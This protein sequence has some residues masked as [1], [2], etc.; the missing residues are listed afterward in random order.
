MA[1][2]FPLEVHTPYRRFF[3]EQ[4]EAVTLTLADGE[5][6]VYAGHSSFTAPVRTGFLKIKNAEGLW[7]TAFIDAGIVETSAHKT[8]VLSDSAEWPEEIDP[9]R[10]RQAGERAR[11]TLASGILKFETDNAR[12]SLMRAEFRLKVWETENKAPE[13]QRE[14]H[15]S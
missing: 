4:V 1:Q 3:A 14:D 7:R 8:V 9:E 12:A 10:A 5:I 2:L 11:A 15:P 6:T 13:Y